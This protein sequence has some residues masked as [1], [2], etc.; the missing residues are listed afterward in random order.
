LNS[1]DADRAPDPAPETSE[2]PA[3]TDGAALD[4]AAPVLVTIVAVTIVFFLVRMLGAPWPNFP[5][6]YPDSF[7]YLK[8]AT[9]GPFHPEFYFT[10]RPIGYPLLLWMMGRSSTLIVVAQSLVYVAAWVTLGWVVVRTIESRAVAFVAVVFFAALAIE[11]RN[12]L[13]NAVVLSESLSTSLAV[14]AIAMWWRAASRPS[15]GTIT[16]AWVA[17]AAWILVRDTNVLPTVLVLLPAVLLLVWRGPVRDKVLRKRLLVGAVVIFVCCGYVY[18]SQA[19]SHRT[20]YSVYN[21][22]GMRVLPDKSLT[23]WFVARGMPMSDALRGRT[24]HNAWDD[25]QASFLDAPDLAQFRTWA[26]GPGARWQLI[27]MGVQAPAWWK[28]LHHELPNILRSNDVEYDTYHVADRL[29]NH[30]PGPLGTPRGTGVLW[31]WLALTTAGLVVAWTDRRRRLLAYM[32]TVALASAIVDIWTSYI[33]DPMEVN[34]HMV[35]P[36][37]R[38]CVT[39]ILAIALGTDALITRIRERDVARSEP[40][41]PSAA[42]APEEAVVDA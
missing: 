39:M 2:A 10:E 25:G 14:F 6:S 40:A 4:Q 1:L 41:E 28:R 19:S 37:A 18:V 13:W 20:Q 29:P 30:F 15:K 3:A 22:V 35:G 7:S 9:L 17:T 26:R 23:D 21:F 38:L 31:A 5:P 32:V 11:P 36:L 33:G 27:S 24:N 34:R 42:E 12:S 16:W 8:V